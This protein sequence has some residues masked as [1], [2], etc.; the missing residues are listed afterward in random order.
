[1]TARPARLVLIGLTLLLGTGHAALADEAAWRALKTGGMVVLMRHA[2]PERGP[3]KGDSLLR[4]ASCARERNLSQ[5]G[6]DEARRVGQAFEARGIAVGEVWSSPYC[7][8]RDTA[9]IAFGS[10]QPTDFLSLAEVLTPA[11][12]ARHTAEAMRQIGSYRGNANRVMVTHE[13]NIAAISFEPI[14]VGAFLVLRPKG[15]SD[16]DVVGKITPGDLAF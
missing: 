6:K 10:A 8:T 1:M 14:E 12:A 11:E 13:P 7:R 3:G 15:D 9:R 5:Q 16:F 2:S 4:D